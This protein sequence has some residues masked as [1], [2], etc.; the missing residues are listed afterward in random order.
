[1]V[2]AFF[3]M[4]HM[5]NKMNKTYIAVVLNPEKVCP[6]RPISLCNVSY[7]TNSKITTNRLMM[8]RNKIRSPLQSVLS[9]GE[10]SMTIS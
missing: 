1:M 9:R 8:V 4:G 6:Y 5:L 2:K 10:V 7:K 3:Y